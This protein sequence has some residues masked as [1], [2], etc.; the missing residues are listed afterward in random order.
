M[1]LVCIF[2]L[3]NLIHRFDLI[4]KV[5]F[6]SVDLVWYIEI[7]ILDSVATKYKIHNAKY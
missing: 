6:G 2:G 1:D 3:I 5:H 4:P 7:G